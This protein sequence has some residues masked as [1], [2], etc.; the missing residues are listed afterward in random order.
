MS[1]VVSEICFIE[2]ERRAELEK[3][4]AVAR[5]A[6]EKAHKASSSKE[7]DIAQQSSKLEELQGQLQATEEARSIL[8]TA[9]EREKSSAQAAIDRA[10]KATEEASLSGEQG[11]VEH[12]RHVAELRAQL[13]ASEEAHTALVAQLVMEKEC[14]AR[15]KEGAAAAAAQLARTRDKVVEEMREQVDLL[16]DRAAMSDARR[17]KALEDLKG[18]K[19]A[20]DD[21]SK[22]VGTERKRLEALSRQLEEA[23]DTLE[24]LALDKEQLAMDLEIAEEKI[25]TLSDAAAT[26]T[27]ATREAGGF[28]A[29]SPTKNESQLTEENEKLR[30]ALHRLNEVTQQEVETLK[31]RL[32]DGT[33]E[34]AKERSS[35]AD[36]SLALQ[37]AETRAEIAEQQLEDFRER[38]DALEGSEEM[39][40]RLTLNEGRLQSK[41]VQ[42]TQDV[43]DLEASAEIDRELDER[44]RQ[45]IQALQ[46][47]VFAG[48]GKA[49]SQDEKLRV[50]SEAL[51]R[52][53]DSTEMQGQVTRALREELKTTESNATAVLSAAEDAELS[54]SAATQDLRQLPLL[55]DAGTRSIREGNAMYTYSQHLLPWGDFPSETYSHVVR[56]RERAKLAR[57]AE[58]CTSVYIQIQNAV[59][60]GLGPSSSS[61]LR[62]GQ[63]LTSVVDALLGVLNGMACCWIDVGLTFAGA[64]DKKT[65]LLPLSIDIIEQRTASLLVFLE[66]FYSEPSMYIRRDDA[67]SDELGGAMRVEDVCVVLG[68]VACSETLQVAAIPALTGDG[69]DEHHICVAV[70]LYLHRILYLLSIV[71][72]LSQLA[73]ASS[74]ANAAFVNQLGVYQSGTS[75]AIEAFSMWS[76]H[77]TGHRSPALANHRETLEVLK[78]ADTVL[79]TMLSDEWPSD[80]ASISVADS[81]CL[82]ALGE[83]LDALQTPAAR[84]GGAASTASS[85]AFVHCDA[86]SLFLQA[87]DT[88]DSSALVASGLPSKLAADLGIYKAPW[89]ALRADFIS[90]DAVVRCPTVVRLRQETQK[91]QDSSLSNIQKALKRDASDHELQGQLNKAEA[92]EKSLMNKNVAIKRRVG[93]LEELLSSVDGREAALRKEVA[94]L[95]D[96]AER[97]Q[98]AIDEVKTL[99]EA[100]EVLEQRQSGSGGDK[101]DKGGGA[102]GTQGAADRRTRGKGGG[103]LAGVGAEKFESEGDQWASANL[104]SRDHKACTRSLLLLAKAWRD[105]ALRKLSV[106]LAVMPSRTSPASA[107]H[108]EG[109]ARARSMY[110]SV[111]MSRASSQV[112]AL[113][114][115]PPGTASSSLESHRAKLKGSYESIV[116]REVAWE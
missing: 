104:S 1:L 98:K 92:S 65:S 77:I 116:A 6:A 90:I 63:A 109:S 87:L 2:W 25:L 113:G 106:H 45:E 29:A 67:L 72:Q 64:V 19:A 68:T 115:L 32:A 53:K 20:M 100:L 36:T 26:P 10:D 27:K 43:S 76:H 42:L 95:K 83:S 81:A 86:A 34:S 79:R 7:L 56:R 110:R 24:M 89:S 40:E 9:L 22:S 93:E 66:Q 52:A 94:S 8:S 37:E 41:I 59:V 107:S 69:A 50:L 111:R 91:L 48:E 13:Q 74:A 57:C 108:L 55:C 15:D 33:A 58:Q 3:E 70:Q 54:S 30:Q 28:E 61:R 11:M 49:E 112:L 114:T 38:L 97:G 75:T 71:S 51:L 35:R 17:D 31:A 12:A 96:T 73:T 44:Q 18:A 39:V 82:K 62:G 102:Q 23:N 78:Q 88:R 85:P 101:G 21:T 84:R 105:V 60:C 14:A 46:Q 5:S 47:E 103:L 99:S 80:P 16:T 4:L